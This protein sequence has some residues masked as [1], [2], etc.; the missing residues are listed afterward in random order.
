MVDSGWSCGGRGGDVGHTVLTEG[1]GGPNSSTTSGKGTVFSSRGAE[2]FNDFIHEA[3]L[4]EVKRG[5]LKFTRM[6]AD[7]SKLSKLDRFLV[8]PNLILVLPKLHSDHS[9]LLL[10][11][12]SLDFGPTYFKF[13]NSWLGDPSLTS[14]VV[15]NW[16]WIP[17]GRNPF[18][19][20]FGKAQTFET[21][22]Q[23]LESGGIFRQER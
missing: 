13:F 9:P 5:G 2:F 11:G 19:V 7:G 12:S 17:R 14:L 20:V 21:P 10:R 1:G 4:T 8:T 3:G 23:V 22:H 16:S 6:S 18:T 15:A